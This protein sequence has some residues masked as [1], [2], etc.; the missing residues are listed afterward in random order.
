VEKPVGSRTYLNNVPAA[1]VWR[2]VAVAL[3]PRSEMD[4]ASG[5][6]HC[7]EWLLHSGWQFASPTDEAQPPSVRAL[8]LAVI[9]DR[10]DS[11]LSL[12]CA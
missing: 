10:S 12:R 7:R 1:W 3:G 9:T 8:S 5:G 2:W 6:T 11:A 4:L